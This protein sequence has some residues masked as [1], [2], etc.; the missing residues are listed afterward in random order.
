[1]NE[2]NSAT[3]DNNIG[4]V[5][6]ISSHHQALLE[7]KIDRVQQLIDDCLNRLEK[8]AEQQYQTGSTSP[9]TLQSVNS[10]L[11]SKL[12]QAQYLLDSGF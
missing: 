11:K 10:T 1:M 6:K 2:A 7:Q 4:S 9:D 3:L 5:N 8:V 12:S